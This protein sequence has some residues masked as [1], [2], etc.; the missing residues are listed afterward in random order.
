MRVYVNA[1]DHGFPVT[2]RG[3]TVTVADKPSSPARSASKADWVAF[4]VS[5]GADQDE[6]E[7]STKDELIA[8][9][10]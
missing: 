5:S 2:L 6:A 3:A 10:G 9:W 4:A 1:T 7:T 8:A